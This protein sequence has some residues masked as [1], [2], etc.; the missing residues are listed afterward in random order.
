MS[1]KL[2]FITQTRKYPFY[3]LQTQYHAIMD[4]YD[5]IYNTL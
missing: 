1:G 4:D 3:A 5:F 2:S